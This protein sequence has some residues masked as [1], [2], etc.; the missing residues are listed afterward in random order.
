MTDSYQAEELTD[1]V[2]VEVPVPKSSRS[3]KSAAARAARTE[4]LDAVRYV[5]LAGLLRGDESAQEAVTEALK[6][7]GFYDH[8][9]GGD[10][11]RAA[12]MRL[13]RYLGYGHSPTG[14]PDAG[15]LTWLALRT[16]NFTATD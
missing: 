4:P 8:L 13:Q 11:F 6:A 9:P 14:V 1:L 10:S 3:R 16:Q 12:Y 2:P 15:S 7:V 5:S